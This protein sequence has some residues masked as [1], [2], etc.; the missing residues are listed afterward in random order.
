[1]RAVQ[2]CGVPGKKS[3]AWTAALRDAHLTEETMTFTETETEF[4]IHCLLLARE[5]FTENA[6]L[7]RV[8]PVREGMAEHFD[9][10]TAQAVALI[11]RL[12]KA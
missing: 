6:Q 2:D 11:D 10:Q 8:E 5:R 7:L 4:L 9:R 12:N 3:A 1:M